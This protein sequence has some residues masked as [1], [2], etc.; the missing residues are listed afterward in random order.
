M[1][2]RRATCTIQIGVWRH[3][4]NCSTFHTEWQAYKNKGVS[5]VNWHG[6]HEV[7]HGTVATLLTTERYNSMQVVH[8]SLVLTTIII[9]QSTRANCGSSE[10]KNASRISHRIEMLENGPQKSWN[11]CSTNFQI[12]LKLTENECDEMYSC[13]TTGRVQRIMPALH[14]AL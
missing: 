11:Y 1:K 3:S 12:K 2:P 14:S 4:W 7:M 13:G 5:I 8:Y 9:T 10:A 6:C